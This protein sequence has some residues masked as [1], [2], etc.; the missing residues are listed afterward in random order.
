MMTRIFSPLALALAFCTLAQAEDLKVGAAPPALTLE[1]LQGA[2]PDFNDPKATIVVE[3]WA[4]WCGPCMR[5]I[6]HLNELFV[7]YQ[8]KGLVILGIS[9]EPTGTVRP[10]LD[11]KGS[12]MSY[13]VGVDS[14]EKA[15]SEAWMKAAG[16]S[17]IPCAF[18][19]KESKIVWIGNPL[20]SK[21]DEVVLG[22]VSG[23]Y[24]PALLRQ[25]EPVKAAAATAAK[26]KN[27][28]D[29]WKHYDALIA[30]DQTVFGDIAVKKYRTMLVDAN[31]PTGAATWGAE[32][33]TK[34]GEDSVTLEE[35]ARLILS[36]SA[37]KVRDY[38]LAFEAAKQLQVLSSNDAASTALTA[39]VVYHAGELDRAVTL[40]QEAW[41][42]SSPAQKTEFRRV[43]DMYRKA[44]KK[45]ATAK[46]S[47]DAPAGDSA[48]P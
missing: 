28:S 7:K 8:S 42:A 21:F 1:M 45:S 14:K 3:F 44:A 9:D 35:L 31:D 41:M 40:Q 32:I 38:T 11:R 4:T 36:D 6:P 24:N 37:I 19:V 30:T 5:S 25:A 2:Q 12:T 39:E 48:V 13:P 18:I 47:T 27:W 15:T 33:V 22:C 46:L 43:L 20:D 10:F 34:Y 16:Q 23:R 29:V 17:G 26:V